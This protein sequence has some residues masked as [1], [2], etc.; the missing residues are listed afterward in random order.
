[1]PRECPCHGRE[2]HGGL[3]QGPPVTTRWLRHPS[4]MQPGLGVQTPLPSGHQEPRGRASSPPPPLGLVLGGGTW[5]LR[6]DG[7]ARACWAVCVSSTSC[8]WGLVTS[9]CRLK[10]HGQPGA[11]GPEEVLTMRRTGQG[12]AG[13]ASGPPASRVQRGLRVAAP[14]L[15]QGP[16]CLQPEA[17]PWSDQSRCGSRAMVC[18]S[19]LEPALEASWSRLPRPGYGPFDS[20]SQDPGPSPLVKRARVLPRGSLRVRCPGVCEL[21]PALGTLQ[22]YPLP[23]APPPEPPSS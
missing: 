23:P 13:W 9:G 2:A 1:M 4:G 12:R 22:P 15:L 21:G 10:L 11:S 20:S 8:F 19:G 6:T 7:Q 16:Q 14:S 18:D 17:W 5:L 3:P